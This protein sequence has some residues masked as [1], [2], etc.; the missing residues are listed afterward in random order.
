MG[1]RYDFGGVVWGGAFELT[2]EIIFDGVEWGRV[3]R[4]ALGTRK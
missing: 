2:Y 1:R 3:M 4:R